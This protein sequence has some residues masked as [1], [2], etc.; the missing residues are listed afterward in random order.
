MS[1]ARPSPDADLPAAL[2][3]D[4]FRYAVE[5]PHRAR[6]NPLGFPL[7]LE[8]NSEEILLAAEQSWHGF[9]AL[10]P[11]PELH[12]RV[13]VE[14]APGEEPV[15]TPVFRAAG[16]L[17]MLSSGP[18]N[19]ACCD[20]EE[21]RAFCFTTPAALRR[22]AQ[23]RYDYLDSQVYAMLNY[24][25]VATVHAGVVAR[26][27]RALLLEGESGAGKSSLAFA[28]ARRGFTL[29]SD[30]AGF[31]LR[32]DPSLTVLG[33]P[34][35][36]R[37]EEGAR[38]LF[39]ELSRYEP[40]L[41]GGGEESMEVPASDF[42]AIRTAF[43]AAARAVVFLERRSAGPARLRTVRPEEALTRLLRQT[44]RLAAWVNREQTETFRRLAAQ[45]AYALEYSG[46]DDAV[47]AL[48][49]LPGERR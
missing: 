38:A 45:G 15:P 34:R 12:M 33:N 21:S 40:A 29:L 19:F 43:R 42:P 44:P 35:F 17:L 48:A 26:E 41:A 10:F 9:E 8:T 23:L 11:G 49:R 47:E 14:D 27:G 18:R 1:E 30:D 24:R 36:L 3:W 7:H 22:P 4:P 13:C 2:S 39:P 46:L 37:F 6:L 20:L 32:N 28:C 16:R 31:I 5:L 25:S